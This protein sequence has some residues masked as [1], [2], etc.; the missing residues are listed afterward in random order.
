VADT[1]R[2][3]E[4]VSA[5]YGW[6]VWV[7]PLTPADRLPVNAVRNTRTV[8]RDLQAGMGAGGSR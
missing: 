8:M 1:R 2:L 7:A 3:A 4:L 5:K 6:P